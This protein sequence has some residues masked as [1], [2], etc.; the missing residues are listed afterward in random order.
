M[1]RI[2][3]NRLLKL[4]QHL[5]KGKLAHKKFNYA[6][7]SAA[8]VPIPEGACG[9][10]GCALGECPAIFNGW[11]WTHNYEAGGTYY[12]EVAPVYKN[13]SWVRESADEFFGL[14]EHQRDFLFFGLDKDGEQRLTR[15]RK[16]V[17]A[18]I[19]KFVQEN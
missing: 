4:A 12:D 19:K 18:R 16:F 1:K 15:T 7:F 17:A 8:N 10:S 3:K 2:Y 13:N 5:Q 9:T 11:K 14:T 6:V